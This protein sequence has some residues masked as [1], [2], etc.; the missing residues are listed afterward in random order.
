MALGREQEG[1]LKDLLGAPWKNQ[2]FVDLLFLQLHGSERELLFLP[3]DK[4][5][6]A[7]RALAESGYD[8][9]EAK[10][11]MDESRWQRRE[12]LFKDK[13][14]VLAEVLSPA[15]LDEYRLRNSPGGDTLRTELQYFNCTPEEF[16]TLLDEREK[17]GQ[18]KVS[19]GDLLDRSAATEQVRKLLGDERA[20]EF[21]R[22][23]DLVYINARRAAQENSLPIDLADRVWELWRD[24]RERGQKIANAR[25]LT[26]EEQRNQLTILTTKADTGISD[27][28]GSDA[29]QGLRRDVRNI[30]NG[31]GA[32][33]GK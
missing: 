14:R 26:P 4:Q 5:D 28:M 10:V 17:P 16:K 27:L 24:A 31:Y 15:E 18:E 30:M 29:S 33:I 20:A 12:D 21:E 7:L 8:A 13:L 32:R 22:V 25:D 2:E 3:G 9:K 1:V 19:W 6:A 11:E 23:T